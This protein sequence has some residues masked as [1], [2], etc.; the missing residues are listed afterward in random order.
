MDLPWSLVSVLHNEAWYVDM[1]AHPPIKN[2]LSKN[3]P[4]VPPNSIR[5]VIW[6][7]ASHLQSERGSQRQVWSRRKRMRVRE[8]SM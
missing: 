4:T 1:R 6:V 5:L 2:G 7:L 3:L 8:E